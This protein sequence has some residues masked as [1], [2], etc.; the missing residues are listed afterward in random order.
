MKKSE[1]FEKFSRLVDEES[2]EVE[3]RL[4]HAVSRQIIVRA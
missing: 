1:F 2:L 4:G 3:T